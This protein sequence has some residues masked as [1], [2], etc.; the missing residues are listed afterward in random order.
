ME[1]IVTRRKDGSLMSLEPSIKL[2]SSEKIAEF[3]RKVMDIQKMTKTIFL[4]DHVLNRIKFAQK[5]GLSYDWLLNQL[6]IDY[7]KETGL[8]K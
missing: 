6:E 5:K 1:I 3:D 2:N 8:N 4:K 7:A